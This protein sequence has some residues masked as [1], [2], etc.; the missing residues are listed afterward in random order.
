VA[1]VRAGVQVKRLSVDDD[2]Y[3]L[4]RSAARVGTERAM[5][6]RRLGRYLQ[7]LYALHGQVIA[8]DQLF[9]KLGAAI[10][11]AGRE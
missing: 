1:S 11:E 4:A 5:R 6:R 9:M 2:V 7:R 10:H 3:L 8:R